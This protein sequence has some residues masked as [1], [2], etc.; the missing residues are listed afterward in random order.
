[1]SDTNKMIL[2]SLPDLHEYYNEEKDE[3][4]FWRYHQ[5]KDKQK[6]DV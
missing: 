1:M 5:D 2:E 6:N 3:I 4:E